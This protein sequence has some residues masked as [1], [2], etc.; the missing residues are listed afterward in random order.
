ME[1]RSSF[2]QLMAQNFEYLAMRDGNQG[3][4]QQHLSTIV[5]GP[6]APHPVVSDF[7]NPLFKD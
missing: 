1:G 4:K 2:L 5:L 6:A 3:R 7:S